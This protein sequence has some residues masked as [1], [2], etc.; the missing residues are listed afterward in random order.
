MASSV[1]RASCI[2]LCLLTLTGRLWAGE[3]NTLSEKS[4]PPPPREF[5]AAWIATVAN[6]DW[7]SKPGLPVAQQKAELVALIDR[8]AQLHFNAIFF[9]VRSVA[10]AIYP[11]TL[12]PW[13]EYLTGLQGRAPEPFYDP[14]ALALAEAHK[15]GLELQV[16][17][18][19][20]RAAHPESKSPP[21]ANHV[22]RTHPELIRRYGSQTVMDPGEPETQTRSLAAIMDVVNR[23]DVD[24]VVIDDYFYPYP[25][26]NRAGQDLDFP[27]DASWRKYGLATGMTRP[28][29]RR[30]NVNRFV[31]KL[32][33]AIKT[34]KPRLQ[35]G[36]SP[37]GIWRPGNPAP[38]RGMD[39]Y[40]KIFADARKWLMDGW[41]DYLSPQLYWTISSP[42]QGFPLLFEWWRGQNIH[43][44][45]IW[46]GLADFSAGT[47]F[48]MDEIPR[49]LQMIRQRN[50]P[51]AV[52][53]HLRSILENPALAAGIA[54]LYGQAVLPPASPWI[55][56]V[57]PLTPKLTVD[58]GEKSAH[59]RWQ[60]DG[61]KPVN[62][63]VVQG[64]VN[65][66]WNC[67]VLPAAQM[68]CY[69]DGAMPDAIAVR[70]ADRLGNLSEPA[71]WTPKRYAAPVVMKGAVLMQG[72]GDT[73]QGAKKVQ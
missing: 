41:V 2:I 46:P 35:F 44:R 29:W 21:A 53:Y 13:S 62:W 14:L 12:E 30:E 8:A 72:T 23:Y 66:A 31:H 33:V 19:P 43:G 73:G 64:H 32:A 57:P 42:Q 50:D 63:W 55:D 1:M 59:V 47:K 71:F 45:H 27:D 5:R 34:A 67:R 54:V 61:G 68:D 37:F 20:F 49:Q 11:S 4:V 51:G 9:Q 56:A 10:D 17:F 52:H 60:I 22:T 28:E 38:I 26:K 70:A 39:A 24:G 18:N 7:P 36:V 48:S 3:S 65:G 16:W 69:L 25:E 15:K 58:T 6:I 40:D